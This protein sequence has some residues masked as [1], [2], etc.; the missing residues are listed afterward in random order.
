MITPLSSRI[1][2]QSALPCV[3][4]SVVIALAPW[5]ITWFPTVACGQTP[6]HW[7]A[8]QDRMV[9]DYI[10]A[11]GVTNPRVIGTMRA[12]PRHEFVTPDQRPYTYFDTSLPIG[13]GRRFRLH[14]WSP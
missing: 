3:V 14:T 2:L 9:D 12:I 4:V 5:N 11:E 1:R 13:G 8:E 10:V 7:Q 6:G